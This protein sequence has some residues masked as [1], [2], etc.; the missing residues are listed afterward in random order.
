MGTKLRV[1]HENFCEIISSAYASMT[2]FAL[3]IGGVDVFEL[4]WNAEPIAIGWSGI[5]VIFISIGI[6]VMCRLIR[7]KVP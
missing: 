5:I 2:L 1:V 3:F 6:W 4:E 7:T